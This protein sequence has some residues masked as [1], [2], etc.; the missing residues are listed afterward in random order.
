MAERAGRAR[1]S[2][3]VSVA[4]G[5]KR[6]GAVRAF[7]RVSFGRRRC[8]APSPSHPLGPLRFHKGQAHISCPAFDFRRHCDKCFMET[9]FH[10]RVSS[11]NRR[12]AR[13]AAGEDDWKRARAMRPGGR[14]SAYATRTPRS[15]G[16]RRF[17]VAAGDRRDRQ[18][19]RR[20]CQGVERHPRAQ[21]QLGATAKSP[22]ASKPVPA[23]GDV[24]GRRPPDQVR[25]S[26]QARTRPIGSC[27]GARIPQQHIEN[28]RNGLALRPARPP[29][30]RPPG[31]G[32]REGLAAAKIRR[33]PL[34]TL[35][36]DSARSRPALRIADRQ[37]QAPARCWRPRNSVATR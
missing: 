8:P 12:P 2:L 13:G 23:G 1:G 22:G 29:R 4:V 17:A 34:K 10:A 24:R 18:F 26:R 3:A 21:E 19:V 16:R 6:I 30:R 37:I 32:P 14:H 9:K 11:S 27:A 33:N 35:E 20:D 25:K 5:M 28:A 36:M 15:S 7:G 31:S